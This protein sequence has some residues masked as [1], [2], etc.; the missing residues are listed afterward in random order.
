LPAHR[1]QEISS[2]VLD[3]SRSIAWEQATMKMASAMAVLEYA[4]GTG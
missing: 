2:A 3:G 1:G 4:A